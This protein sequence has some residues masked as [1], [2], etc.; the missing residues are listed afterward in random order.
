MLASCVE[1]FL[2][3]TCHL[4]LSL[5]ITCFF[6]DCSMFY[7]FCGIM[8]FFTFTY[9]F[10]KKSIWTIIETAILILIADSKLL[11]LKVWHYCCVMI[12]VWLSLQ[13]NWRRPKGIDSRVRRK[14]KGCTLMPNIG[15]GSDKKTRHYLPNGFKKFVVH[16]A[17]ELELL[18]MHN[19]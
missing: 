1:V 5:W 10:E 16:N 2:Y 9:W 17:S 19:R 11:G 18:M 13:T 3:W 4:I 6:R 12:R 7:L 8:F 14:F 15:Y